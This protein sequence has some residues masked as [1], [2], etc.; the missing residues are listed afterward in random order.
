MVQTDFGRVGGLQCFEHLQPLLKYNEYYQRVQ[1]HVAS[2]PALFPV[3]GDMPHFN[4]VDSCSMATQMLAVEGGAFALLAS[5]TQSAKGLKANGL[6]KEVSPN[7]IDAPHTAVIGGGFSAIFGPDGRRLTEPTDPKWEGMLYA[8]LDFNQIYIAKQW[9]D[10]V[11]HYS[12][13]DIFS[14]KVNNVTQRH[15]IRDEMETTFEL[16]SRFP[17]LDLD[18]DVLSTSE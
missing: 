10:P 16:V 9:V 4:A 13:P 8:E 3:I 1:I 12:R 18:S 6:G 14:L 7:D 5:H 15:V 2:W 17:Q 11:G